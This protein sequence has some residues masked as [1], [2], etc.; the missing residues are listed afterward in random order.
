[1]AFL[2]EDDFKTRAYQEK[3]DAISEGDDAL[4]PNAI[5]A[6]IAEAK[7]YLSRFDL[8]DL[9][10]KTD[11][12]RDPI[13]LVWCKDIAL[14]QFIGLANPGIDYEDCQTRRNNAIK[15]LKEIQASTGVPIGWKLLAVDSN[16]YNPST[17]MHVSSNPKRNTYRS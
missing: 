5:N 12:D 1:M 13:L 14:W 15:S 10:G 6:A 3:L 17:S 7:L 16:G 9:F 4:L 8:E 11:D 2:T